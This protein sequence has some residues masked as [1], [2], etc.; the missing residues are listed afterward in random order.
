M[1]FRF[2]AVGFFSFFVPGRE[3]EF[4]VGAAFFFGDF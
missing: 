1:L 4:L 2:D 3:L